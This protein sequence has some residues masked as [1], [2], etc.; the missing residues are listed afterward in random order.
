MTKRILFACLS[1]IA[2]VHPLAA[3]TPDTIA[4]IYGRVPGYQYTWW[5]DT[6]C[7]AFF[8]TN[9]NWL[10]NYGTIGLVVGGPD[11]WDDDRI[12]Q[13][14]SEMVDHP[15]AISSIGVIWRDKSLY[16]DMRYGYPVASSSRVPEYIKIFQFDSLADTVW[17]LDSVRWDTAEAKILKLPKHSDTARYGFFPVYFSEI[18]LDS[19]EKPIVVDS[20]FFLLSTHY[21]GY[22][23][24][25][26]TILHNP[27]SIAYFL[28]QPAHHVPYDGTNVWC[29]NNCEGQIPRRRELQMPNS[30]P[31]GRTCWHG[32]DYRECAGRQ[33]YG[34]ILVKIDY[35]N[36]DVRSADTNMGTAGPGGKRSI[37]VSHQIKATPKLGYRFISWNDGNTDNPRSVLLVHD[38]TLTAIFAS[39]EQFEVIAQSHNIYGRVS[40]SG[41]YYIGDTA[42]I[43]AHVRIPGYRFLHWNDRVTTNPRSFAVT[44]DT[45]FTAYFVRNQGIDDNVADS[46]IFTLT[47]NPALT[48]VEVRIAPAIANPSACRIALRDAEGRLHALVPA[49]GETT[50]L[51][52]A[53]LPAGV[54]FVTL[55][56]PQ[57]TA[58]RRLIVN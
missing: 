8:D 37:N 36:L 46:S 42:T 55:T 19:L 16:P 54:Y 32:I 24:N 57:A 45:I 21:N 14:F 10:Q 25:F 49:E 33:M 17:L 56:T 34:G 38:T 30:C 51:S 2:I 44:Q 18:R 27:M 41:F 50:T 15:S 52:T 26:G 47:P 58:T 22:I 12:I 28:I 53:H 31:P 6:N 1:L 3:Q 20:M 40:G 48:E 29:Y 5:Y 13:G 7:N 35:A 9:S 4:S 39:A 43:Q 23:T 11:L